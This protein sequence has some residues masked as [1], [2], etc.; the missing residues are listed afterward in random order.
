MY[1]HITLFK[2]YVTSNQSVPTSNVGETVII[3]V[4]SLI[5]IF[6]LL[7]EKRPPFVNSG[8]SEL[9]NVPYLIFIILL[10]YLKIGLIN[11]SICVCIVIKFK[12]K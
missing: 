4:V 5:L 8:C 2:L 6:D 11:T 9:Y 3:P 12:F 10:L 1:I 7:T